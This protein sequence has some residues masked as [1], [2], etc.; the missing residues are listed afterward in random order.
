VTGI[1][2]CEISGV[3]SGTALG[4]GAIWVPDAGR[5]IIHKIDPKTNQVVREVAAGL[6]ERATGIAAGEG[7][8]W[9]ITSARANALKR[10]SA[11][12]GADQATIALPSRGL[13]VI[14]AFSSI[15]VTG[16]RNDELY[17]IDPATND[18]AAT[19]ELRLRPPSVPPSASRSVHSGYPEPRSAGSNRQNK[20]RASNRLQ[21]TAG[22][23]FRSHAL[24]ASSTRNG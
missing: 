22:G 12:T 10:Y 6:P 11:E 4:E 18:I 8:R 19:I 15:W 14:V 21:R 16:T 17:R 9:A 23:L 5:A 7:S 3:F 24:T 1:P 2:V 13:G 20:V